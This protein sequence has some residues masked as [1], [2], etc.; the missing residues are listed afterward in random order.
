MLLACT[1]VSY[2]KRGTILEE[3]KL[4]FSKC[5]MDWTTCPGCVTDPIWVSSPVGLNL[6][7]FCSNLG[8]LQKPRVRSPKKQQ[9]HEKLHLNRQ[10]PWSGPGRGATLLGTLHSKCNKTSKQSFQKPKWMTPETRRPT[11]RKALDDRRCIQLKLNRLKLDWWHSFPTKHGL[12][13]DGASMSS[14]FKLHKI[15]LSMILAATNMMVVAISVKANHEISN[16]LKF[17]DALA[18]TWPEQFW[19]VL[20]LAWHRVCSQEKR[21]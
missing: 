8:D 11:E 21:K 16:D 2:M 10:K 6:H 12:E 5:R 3:R 20:S 13:E 17:S 1:S 15:Q 18:V 19:D 4:E 7:G 14:M 9:W